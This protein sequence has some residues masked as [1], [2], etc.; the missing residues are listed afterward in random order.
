MVFIVLVFEGTRDLTH[1]RH[2]REPS[3]PAPVSLHGST[4]C[5][6]LAPALGPPRLRHHGR[7]VGC[8]PKMLSRHS[9]APR[10]RREGGPCVVSWCAVQPPAA[11]CLAAWRPGSLLQRTPRRPRRGRAPC[12]TGLP[13][14]TSARR[15]NRGGTGD[16]EGRQ[17]APASER[18]Q[19]HAPARLW[20]SPPP[21][22][23]L[24]ASTP[25]PQGTSQRKHSARR[26]PWA[27]G[28]GHPQAKIL[29]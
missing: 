8:H 25:R 19:H 13:A 5:G 9:H 6:T 3:V 2:T 15:R 14:C 27:R 16:G 7:A 28:A 22:T 18:Q 24:L 11:A 21:R 20:M 4:S 17:P 23:D 26:V 12:C 10:R 1:S 29:P